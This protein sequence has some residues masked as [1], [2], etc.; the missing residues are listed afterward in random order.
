MIPNC[1]SNCFFRCFFFFFF[2]LHRITFT[3]NPSSM[4]TF[5]SNQKPPSR[6]TVKR[7]LDEICKVLPKSKLGTTYLNTNSKSV[8][9]IIE[10]EPLANKKNMNE[11]LTQSD[12]NLLTIE[13]LG[14]Q[15]IYGGCNQRQPEKKLQDLSS[16][17]IERHKYTRPSETRVKAMELKI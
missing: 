12:D 3:M 14:S 9:G 2:H 16:S 13:N 17:D 6:R 8:V 1:N 15:T 11:P 10:E 7:K 4:P 5:Y